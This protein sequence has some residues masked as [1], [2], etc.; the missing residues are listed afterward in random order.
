MSKFKNMVIELMGCLSIP[1]PQLTLQKISL[2]II[3][4]KI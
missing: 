4:K 1:N 3:N 2:D